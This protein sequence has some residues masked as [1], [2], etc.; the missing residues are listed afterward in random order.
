[1]F[2]VGMDASSLSEIRKPIISCGPPEGQSAKRDDTRACGA[3]G[4]RRAS[5]LGRMSMSDTAVAPKLY[6][7]GLSG[8]YAALQP[9]GYPVI[10][11]AAGAILIPHG[12]AKLFGGAAPFVA[13]KVLAPLGFPAP[14]FWVYFLGLLETL[15]VAA[16][17]LGFFTRL[18][19]AMLFV[20][21]LVV[22]FAVHV[23][24]GYSFT[25]QGGGFEYPLLLC[26]LY[27][28]IFMRGSDRCSIDRMIGREL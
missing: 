19:A 8:L 12:W 21:M 3:L 24:R 1:M 6:F 4:S 17:A 28:G 15:G 11:F 23:H 18:F 26:A 10:R 14:Y 22:T 5:A 16:L 25:S 27:L 7:P 9:Y 20:E 2:A 13:E